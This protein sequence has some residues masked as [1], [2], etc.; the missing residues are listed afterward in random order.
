[1]ANSSLTESRSLSAKQ[2]K[3]KPWFKNQ[4]VQALI[5]FLLL[6]SGILIIWE[7]GVQYR[8]FSPVM[9]AASR[10]ISDFFGWVSDPFYDNGP[11]DK[12]IGLHLLASLQRVLLG[13]LLGSAIA[14]PLGVLIGLSDVVSKAVDPFIQLLRPVSPLAWLPLG[15]GILKSSEGTA[16]F[17]I[18][19]TSVWATLINTKFGVS[20]VSTDYLN[21][22][23]TL[24]AS[25]WRTICKVILPAAAPSIVAGLRIS[26]GIS[27]LV[28][29][30]AEM[31]VGGTGLGSFVWAEWNNLN[32]T[33]IITAIVVIGL[34]GI[35][36]DRLLGVLHSWVSFGQ[37]TQ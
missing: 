35:F 28:I 36:L 2:Q 25:R 34:T 31:I 27:W 6:L 5:L 14:I 9:P 8:I 23:R 7:L 37:R 12:G 10:T 19:I 17:V 22:A 33:S 20:N 11:N 29:V 30:A 4:N 15:L 24:G 1:M 16:L 13:F 18:A 3:S 21:V 32:V 26:I